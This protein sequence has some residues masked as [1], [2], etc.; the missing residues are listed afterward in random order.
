M[1]RLV[2]HRVVFRRARARGQLLRRPQW[3][4]PEAPAYVG[5]PYA[6]CTQ[7]RRHP[8]AIWGSRGM[9]ACSQLA[10][11]PRFSPGR[12]AL[13]VLPRAAGGHL[14]AAGRVRRGER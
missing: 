1:Q 12:A 14:V 11:P 9:R 3:A 8:R 6:A 5:C 13:A 2:Q 10:T 7:Q 4:L